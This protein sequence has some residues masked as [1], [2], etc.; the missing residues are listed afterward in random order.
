MVCWVVSGGVVVVKGVKSVAASKR[1]RQDAKVSTT[2]R[3]RLPPGYSMVLPHC[4]RRGFLKPHMVVYGPF[5]C[6]AGAVFGSYIWSCMVPSAVLPLQVSE[7]TYGNVN[8]SNELYKSICSPMRPY[9]T[10]YDRSWLEEIR[11]AIHSHM[12]LYAP[13]Y[14]L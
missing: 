7:A 3:S 10:I 14:R 6:T 4:C 11:G 1:G 5:P 9:V 13:I 12:L 8:K 2:P